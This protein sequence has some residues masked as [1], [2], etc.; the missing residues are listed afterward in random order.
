VHVLRPLAKKIYSKERNVEKYI[1]W[2]KTLSL[3]IQS[4][5]IRLAVL[6]LSP[7]PAKSKTYT[8][9]SS[10]S[11]K[12]INLGANQKPIGNFLLASNSNYG[13]I[14]YHFRDIDV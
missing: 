12:V 2:I 1:Q 9:S 11:S 4:I 3:T 13:R 14:A 6:L 8:G 10:R 5:F 7:K